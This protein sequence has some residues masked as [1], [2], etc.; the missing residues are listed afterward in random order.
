MK[1]RIEID[2]KTFVRFWLV[3]IGFILAGWMI[4]SAR[5]ALFIIGTALFISL[6]LSH[7]VRKLASLLPGK[8]RVGGTALAFVS[9]V[10]VLGAIPDHYSTSYRCDDSG[11]VVFF[12]R[13][14][15]STR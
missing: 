8:S 6:A 15:S 10:L 3:V 7:P 5:E 11:G 2:T 12:R 1:V 9:L 4:F 14:S 13:H